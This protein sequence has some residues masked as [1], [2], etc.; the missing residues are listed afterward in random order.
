MM[1]DIFICPNGTMLENWKEAFPKALV[2]V[3][4]RTVPVN[5]P[6][7]FWVLANASNVAW[8]AQVMTEITT[9][10]QASKIVVLANT[11]NQAD[12]LTV[13]RQGAVGYCHAYSASTMLIELKTVVAHG[14]VWLG[15]DLLQTIINATKPLTYNTSS[16]VEEALE[17]LTSREKEVALEAAKGLSNKAIARVFDITERTVKAHVSAIL[18][19]L[20]VKDRLQLALMLNDKN[21]KS[22]QQSDATLTKAEVFKSTNHANKSSPTSHDVKKKLEKVA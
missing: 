21:T 14:G 18:E 5:E 22:T 19:K 15:N 9:K 17:L 10:F 1:R 13:M 4:T 11:P 7:V 6:V 8:L 16:N 3:S 2:T 20:G 12:A